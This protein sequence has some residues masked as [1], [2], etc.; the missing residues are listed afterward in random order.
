[1][2]RVSI[3]LK[4]MLLVGVHRASGYPSDTLVHGNHRSVFLHYFLRMFKSVKRF[5][6]ETGECASN[7]VISDEG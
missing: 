2:K 5:D 4:E 1:M 6:E 7:L 3:S